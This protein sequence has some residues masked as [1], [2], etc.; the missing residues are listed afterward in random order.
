MESRP[1]GPTFLSIRLRGPRGLSL[2]RNCPCHSVE[3]M[4][5]LSTA[6]CGG[7]AEKSAFHSPCGK[8]MRLFQ[9]FPRA[10]GGDSP[11]GIRLFG[12]FDKISHETL[13]KTSSFTHSFPQL[14]EKVAEQD[15]GHLKSCGNR[16]GQRGSFP[17]TS[18]DDKNKITIHP[19]CEI[20]VCR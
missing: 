3:N 12:I 19:I 8:I 9:T 20:R 10:F 13:C 7:W 16:R 18:R 4:R 14:V 5:R 11:V 15:A 17:Q 1:R 2:W 6:S